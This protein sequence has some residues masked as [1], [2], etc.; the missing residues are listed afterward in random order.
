[1]LIFL[2]INNIRSKEMKISFRILNFIYKSKS[3]IL[4]YYIYYEF[5]S[6]NVIVDSPDYNI[7]TLVNFF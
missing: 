2:I 1:M 3:S 6:R 7:L 5:F 4:N